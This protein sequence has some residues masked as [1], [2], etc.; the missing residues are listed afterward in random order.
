MEADAGAG[1]GVAVSGACGEGFGVRARGRIDIGRFALQVFAIE[2]RAGRDIDA[3]RL[4]GAGK[5]YAGAGGNIDVD[6]DVFPVEPR[7]NKDEF[8][9]PLRGLTT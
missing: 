5:L 8:Q 3:E 2:L 4:A 6:I 7:T 1:R 9:S